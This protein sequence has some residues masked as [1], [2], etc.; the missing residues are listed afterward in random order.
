MTIQN[1]KV[2]NPRGFKSKRAFEAKTSQALYIFSNL[3]KNP[4]V[5]DKIEL[6]DIYLN[7]EFTSSIGTKNNWT[8]I[9]AKIPKKD[10]EDKG[11]NYLIR[12][13][14]LKNIT[15]EIFGKGMT[16][17]QTQVK[18][19]DRLEFDNISSE[20]GF[21]TKELINAIFGGA[22]LQQYI[23]GIF[24]DA[25]KPEKALERVLS[26]LFGKDEGLQQSADPASMD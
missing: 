17:N 20:T 16:K 7:I 12:K 4:T 9:A 3:F 22:G 14:V 1:F 26:P 25:L 15:V 18:K 2:K 10:L 21:P 11:E 6:D 24:Q 13:V 23:K 19:I 5:I 8:K